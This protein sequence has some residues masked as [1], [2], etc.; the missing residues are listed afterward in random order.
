MKTIKLIT[1]LFLS[2]SIFGQELNS[3][4]I[5]QALLNQATTVGDNDVR[6]YSDI[7]SQILGSYQSTYDSLGQRLSSEAINNGL[8]GGTNMI[9]WK[10]AN[11]FS[12]FK[13][14]FNRSIAP[15]LFS[16]TGY[17][18]ND[19]MIIEIDIAKFLN[20]LKSDSQI[21]ISDKNLLAYT[22]LTFKRTFRYNHFAQS[23]E[24]GLQTSYD[25]LF[26]IFSY[27]NSQKFNS[28]S[29]YDYITK[30]DSFELSAGA[31]AT[32]PITSY[33]NAGVGA[34]ASAVK[35]TS[36]TI[37]KLGPDDSK[38]AGEFVR[39]TSEEES[40]IKAQV[41]AVLLLDV[42]KLL[43]MTLL[44]YDYEYE[45]TK[46]YKVY[47]S[48]YEDDMSNS[49]KLDEVDK[50]LKFK[51]F[52]SDLLAENLK[53]EE[54]RESE[55]KQSKYLAF[56]W[57]GLRNSLTE[58]TEILKEGVIYRF[59]THNYEKLSYTENLFSKIL[60]TILGKLIGF[61]Q[62]A[63]NTEVDSYNSSINYE[64]NEN[65]LDNKKDFNI[66]SD[67]VL[68]IEMGKKFSIYAGSKLKQNKI[69]S[70]VLDHLEN[71]AVNVSKINTVLA[72]NKAYA[73]VD[74]SS[75][76][77]LDNNNIAHFMNKNSSDVFSILNSMCKEESK[78]IFSFFRSL[79]SNCKSKAYT[80][81]N[82]FLKEWTTLNY[83]KEVYDDCSKKYRF[84]YL[85]SP[86]KKKEM[87]SK[88]MEIS[89]KNTIDYRLTTFPLW[90]FKDV[91]NNL[92]NN[93]DGINQLEALFGDFSV[94]GTLSMKL[95]NQSNYS[96]YFKSGNYKGNI[97]TQFQIENNLRAPASN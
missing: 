39:I 86:N 22:G 18:V 23:L 79:F 17:I 45:R 42:F 75:T 11:D 97:L 85:F 8:F 25:K 7:Y 63:T 65:I 91:V 35:K 14:L 40:Q 46:S 81:Y 19:E 41:N 5:S 27:F 57:G 52:K 59:F 89:N 4:T 12:S 28:L 48:L 60:S 62:L 26:F 13:I 55:F 50:I 67:N 53:S 64:S 69:Q 77:T 94:Y 54:I 88:C 95:N 49:Q 80:S 71:R 43:N 56:I 61:N 20:Q 16:D 15:D 34:L 10:H 73:P 37:Q 32:S 74:F 3:L 31:M 2:F 36:A 92:N 58:I 29:D 87:I 93:I 1:L 83:S 9:G 90:R 47:L 24:D 51:Y 33:L 68:T 70:K 38:E 66:F 96:T 30:E 82:N 6:Y 21:N 84:K 72:S 78:S 76:S 44:R